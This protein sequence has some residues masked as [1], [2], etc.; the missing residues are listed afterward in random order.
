MRSLIRWHGGKAVQASWIVRQLPPHNVYVEPYG[1]GASVLMRKPP[2][3]VEILNELDGGLVNMYRVVADPDRWKH[4]ALGTMFTKYRDQRPIEAPDPDDPV[5]QAVRL[6]AWGA[7]H[8]NASES[9]GFRGEKPR[10]DGSTMAADWYRYRKSV[11]IFYRRLRD[12]RIEQRPALDVIRE[13]ASKRTLT[14]CDPPYMTGTRDNARHRYPHEMTD[15]DHRELLDCLLSLK[16]MVAISGYDSPLYAEALGHWT[17]L[18]RTVG[19]N[20]RKQRTEVL[21]L[22]PAASIASMVYH[23]NMHELTLSLSKSD[24]AAK[25]EARR[26]AKHPGQLDLLA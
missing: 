13:N 26:L 20:A 11:P 15:D 22:N 18:T 7:M 14:Y 6:V 21:W 5:A 19:D 25:K 23:A 12:V 16:G 24:K 9:S 2:S 3:A 8:R 10:P 17:R 4:F 1:G